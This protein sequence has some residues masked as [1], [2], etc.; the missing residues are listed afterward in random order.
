MSNKNK[1]VSRIFL[2]GILLL[3]MCMNITPALAQDVMEDAKISLTFTDENDVK[4]IVATATDQ[5]GMPI[6]DLELYFFVQRTFSLLPFG[7]FFNST[8]EN[9]EVAVEFPGD[10]PGDIEGNVTIL[11]KI[12]ESDM[13]NDLSISNT[14]NWGVPVEI[15]EKE[16]KRSLW[17]SAA[18]A[19]MTLIVSVSFMIFAVWYIICFILFKLYRISRMKPIKE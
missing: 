4:T 15:D 11:V 18:N 17:A 5:E 6:A 7:D 14:K 13:Y 10:L 2:N 9:G 19:P 1:L 16:E 3:M 12:M 8:D